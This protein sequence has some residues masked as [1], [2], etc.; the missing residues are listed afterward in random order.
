MRVQLI[1]TQ[2]T[3]FYENPQPCP[4]HGAGCQFGICVACFLYDFKLT[5]NHFQ[6]KSL[7]PAGPRPKRERREK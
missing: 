7:R 2:H 5:I 4:H 3:H 1:P 6:P